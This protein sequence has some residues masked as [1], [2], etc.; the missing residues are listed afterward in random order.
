MAEFLYTFTNAGLSNFRDDNRKNFIKQPVFIISKAILL[1]ANHRQF[2]I[3]QA[4]E[5]GKNI[6]F[7]SFVSI[8]V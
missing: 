8:Q 6:D 4:A 5:I 1:P 2:F 7:F 3:Y